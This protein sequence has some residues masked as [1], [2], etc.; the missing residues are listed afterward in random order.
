[1]SVAGRVM[2]GFQAS[3]IDLHTSNILCIRIIVGRS[4]AESGIV[5]YILSKMISYLYHAGHQAEAVDRRY[6]PCS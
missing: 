2:G 5:L 6:P 4:E 3:I 1:M